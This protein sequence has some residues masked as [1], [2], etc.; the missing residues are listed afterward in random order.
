MNAPPRRVMASYPTYQDAEHA[1]DH[2][3]GKGFPVQ[4]VAISG[5]NVQ[6]VER[7]IDRM[8]FSEAAVR[9][10]ASGALP[11]ALIGWIFGC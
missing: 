9:G 3:T 11:G 2:L 4:K 6:P 7:V 10:A 5:Q 8:G 1:V